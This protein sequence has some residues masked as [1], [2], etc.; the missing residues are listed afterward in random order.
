MTPPKA[1]LKEHN[2]SCACSGIARYR[3]AEPGTH[4]HICWESTELQLYY[5]ISLPKARGNRACMQGG[6]QPHL[7]GLQYS[8][9]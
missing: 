1:P 2:T 7:R 3:D 9:A 6:L 4:C 8:A 5:T